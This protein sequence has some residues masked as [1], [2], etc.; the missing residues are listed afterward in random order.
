MDRTCRPGSDTGHDVLDR[1]RREGRWWWLQARHTRRIW[2]WALLVAALLFAAMALLRRPLADWLWNEPRI[3]RTLE[4]ADAAL[5]S[6]RLTAADGSGARELFQAA[7]AQDGDRMRARAGLQ[8]TGA[9]ALQAGEAALQA[10]ELEQAAEALAL[11]R[12]L[13]V[14]RA[15]SEA[16]AQ[17]LRERH[18]GSAGL[19]QLLLRAQAALAEGR[20]DADEDSALPLLQRVLDLRPENVAALE[21][22]EDAL[23]DLLARA[24]QASMDGDV[25]AAAQLLARAR[26]YDPG[27]VDLPGSQEALSRALESA[28][29]RATA[30]LRGGRLEVALARLAP[31]LQAAPD[32]AAVVALRERLLRALVQDSRRHAG[33]L[34]FDAAERRL[35]QAEQL[36]PG[37][38]DVEAARQALQRSRLAHDAARATPQ[39]Q[40]DSRRRLAG[41]LQRVADAEARGNFLG[42]PGQ[43]AYDA[44]RE[45]QALAPRD[46]RVGEAAE[47]LLPAS[48]RCFE[49]A[50][51]QNRVQAAGGCLQ[52]WQTLAPVDGDLGAA[53]SR[54]AQR[55]LAVGSERLGSGDLAFAE[56]AV[57][58]ARQLQPGLPEL[59]AFQARVRQAG[60]SER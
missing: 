47:R 3:E 26:G 2:R 46:R 34:R 60:G 51:R 28:L 5:A 25:V 19:E 22:R 42:P 30:A 35:A 12:A 39:A 23:G 55:W 20:L 17:R 18:A 44:L 1:V 38:R 6:G 43:S 56:R 41:L 16:F 13:Q 21:A 4:Q 54:L 31:A 15:R 37:A 49:D 27:H 58:Q 59:D 14:P 9:A 52:A 48:R 45:A 7:L 33:A 40:G 24:R 36:H 8:R 11:A 10:G 29:R 32:E 50:L 57:D 53:R